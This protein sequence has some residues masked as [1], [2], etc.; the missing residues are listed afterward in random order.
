MIKETIDLTEHRD[1]SRDT[2]IIHFNVESR[3]FWHQV[4]ADLQR[5]LYGKL[6]WKVE[7]EERIPFDGIFPLGNKEQRKEIVSM[8]YWGS[9]DA[10]TC[11]CCGEKI[12]F[13][14][15]DKSSGICKRCKAEMKREIRFPWL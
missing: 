5:R 9:K 15:W 6:I 8:Y 12:T 10:T 7:Q 4:N 3:D 11:D 14:P 2:G 1:F 13:I